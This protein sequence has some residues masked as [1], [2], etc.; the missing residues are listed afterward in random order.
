[1]WNK[2]T[3]ERFYNK[4]AGESNINDAKSYDEHGNPVGRAY[5][6]GRDGS[7]KGYNILIGQ[8]YTAAD[9]DVG[10]GKPI[11]ALK[12]KGF[13]IKHVNNES[14]FLSELRS[15]RYHI[16]WVISTT[17]IS[18]T[19]FISTLMD[20]HLAGVAVFLF[21]DNTPYVCHASDFLNK[22]F[23]VTLVG[24]FYG[25]KTLNYKENGYLS[26]GNFGKHDI[27]TGIGHLFEGITICHPVYS[28][29]G[30]RELLRTLATATD[31]NPCISVFDPSLK[32]PEGR[33]CLD[34]GF[35]KLYINWDDAGTARYI[36]NVSC[37]LA[38][39][40]RLY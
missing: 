34:C 36:V 16:A 23:G 37:W 6:L 17:H 1:M 9:F 31:G 40:D 7:F 5:D 29:S 3:S 24:D 18:D 8:F 38:G 30:S 35:T 19:T 28:T 20:F 12:I 25:G 39:V 13:E 21:A 11:N 14:A 32:S 2:N 26:A 4:S 27:F 15:K 10:M 22:K 33:L